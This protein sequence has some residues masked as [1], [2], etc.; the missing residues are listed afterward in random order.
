MEVTENNDATNSE[1]E[2]RFVNIAEEPIFIVINDT[3]KNEVLVDDDVVD[4]LNALYEEKE[5][6]KTLIGLVNALIND[7]GSETLI[8]HWD[9]MRDE[10]Y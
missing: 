1:N 6:C 8:R 9:G 7:L 5:F 10:K 2:K 3:F 4:K